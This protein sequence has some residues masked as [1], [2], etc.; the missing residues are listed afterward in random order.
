MRW[1]ATIA[2]PLW[3]RLDR[4]LPL[5]RRGEN[6]AAR[7]LQRLGYTIVGRGQRGQI[8]EIDLVAV[9]GRMVVFVEVK[10]RSSQDAGHPADAVDDDKQRRLT[11][12]ALAYL[13]RHDLL[14]CASRFDVVA[15]TWPDLRRPPQ[16][17]HF[18][19]A[20]EAVGFDGMYS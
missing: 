2:E 7:H 13:K 5:G 1:L 3:L 17:E 16:I 18:Q 12:L 8:G 9:D 19:S 14:E 4:R 20:F 15:I 6:A 10:T 11:R